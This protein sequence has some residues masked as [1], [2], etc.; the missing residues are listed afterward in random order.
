MKTEQVPFSY[1]EIKNPGVTGDY[2]KVQPGN[3]VLP[4]T[5][6]DHVDDIYNMD[7]KPDDVV[8]LSWPKTGTHWTCELV[9]NIC[10]D[11][12]TAKAKKIPLMDRWRF[13]D[14][15]SDSKQMV[16]AFELADKPMG[17][18]E[19]AL[20]G[21]GPRYIVS[22]LPLS[23]FPPKILDTCKVV[24]VTRNPM[25]TCVSLF[26][27][28]ESRP[29]EKQDFKTFFDNFI[30]GNVVFSP[31]WNHVGEAWSLRDHPNLCFLTFEDMKKDLRK[32]VD[33][34]AKFF[35][36]D[37]SEEQVEKLI[38]HLSFDSMQKNPSVNNE[39]L[40]KSGK[41]KGNAQFIR[42]GVVGDFKN[43]LTPAMEQKMKSW[44]EQERG[45][46]DLR[47]EGVEM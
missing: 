26:R 39:H 30:D 37:L 35:N 8:L 40:K 45:S 31:Y 46:C 10:N 5:I 13:I 32:T 47:F 36:K 41:V 14:V 19:R 42:K 17:R 1:Q 16:C 27:F 23:L 9:W 15:P 24:Y 4:S 43:H 38:D 34:V 29:D 33:D 25:D 20:D 3:Y 12:D 11:I 2:V 21:S 22:H 28:L 6:K 44:C 18:I 7:L